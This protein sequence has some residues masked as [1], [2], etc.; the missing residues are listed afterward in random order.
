MGLMTATLSRTGRKRKS[1]VRRDRSGKSL[2]EIIDLAVVLNQPHRKGASD[3]KSQLLGYPLGR[4]RLSGEVTEAQLEAGNV[5]A[6]LV[7]SYARM[8]GVPVGSPKTGS[9]SGCVSTG[10]YAWEGETTEIDEDEAQRRRAALRSRY[11]ACHD[12]LAEVG[13]SLG[14]GTM[15]LKACRKICVEEQPPAGRELGDLRVGL[16]AL[17]KVLHG[18]RA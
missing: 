2:G 10:F 5:W 12:A 17:G 14:Q 8:L 9:M 16:N 13:N 4:L 1:N 15:I 7:R 18:K 11:N 3:P 6:S